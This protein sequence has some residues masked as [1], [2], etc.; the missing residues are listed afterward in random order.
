METPNISDD[1]A[2]DPL[3]HDFFSL[4]PGIDDFIDE[5]DDSPPVKKRR[6]KRAAASSK[7][8]D[9]DRQKQFAAGMYDHYAA[10]LVVK[11]AALGGQGLFARRVLPKGY[12]IDYFGQYFNSVDDLEDSGRGSSPYVIGKGKKNQYSLLVDGGVIPQQFAIY[13]N[14]Q[15]NKRANAILAWDSDRYLPGQPLLD[16]KRQVM[17]GEEITVDYGPYFGYKK[18][19]FRR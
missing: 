8:T 12:T 18:Q 9:L 10:D 3:G 14:H 19:G 6:S 16:L 2:Y 13:A 5:R 7:P 1:E 17:P 15:S 4:G 11:P